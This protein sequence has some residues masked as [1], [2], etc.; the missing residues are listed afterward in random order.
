MVIDFNRLNSTQPLPGN[1]RTSG[2]KD[3]VEAKPLPAKAEQASASQSGESVHLSNEA[4]QLQKI[5]DSLRDQPIVNKA[6][7]AELKQAIADGTYT[8]DSNR[9]ASKLLN[10]EAER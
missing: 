7:V 5:T 4:Q 10:F 6:R 9:V 1:T 2:A 8:V 3:S